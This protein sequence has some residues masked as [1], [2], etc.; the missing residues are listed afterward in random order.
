M[1]PEFE[2]GGDPHSTKW[3]Q[4]GIKAGQCLQCPCGLPAP[5]SLQP[6]GVVT[7]ATTCPWATAAGPGGSALLQRAHQFY[8]LTMATLN[9]PQPVSRVHPMGRIH[10]T[11]LSLVKFWR[12]GAP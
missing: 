4:K 5:P 8:S 6:H 1:R 10:G 9:G 2:S 11:C 7:M 12:L 3:I